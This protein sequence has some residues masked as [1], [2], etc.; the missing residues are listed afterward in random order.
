MFKVGVLMMAAAALTGSVAAQELNWREMAELPRPVAGYMA[1]IVRGKLLIVG[2]SYWENK[3]KHWADLVQAFD[4]GTN[5]WSNLTPLPA[6]R[7]DAASVTIANDLYCFGGGSG[8]EVRADV[9][10]FHNGAW[11]KVAEAD[12]PEPRLYAV[13]ITS[14]GWV[15]VLGGISKAGDYKVMSPAFWRWRPGA[16]KWETLEPLPGP[17]RISHA[18]AELDGAIYVFG[19]ATTGPQ[20]VENLQDAYEYDTRTGK[21]TRLPDLSVANR[22]WWS[23]GVGNRALVL[24]G[25]T[26]DFAKEVY[27]YEPGQGLQPA[28]A[29]PHGLADTKF[30]RIGNVIVGAGGE[31][32]PGI[33]GKWTLA[34]EL[35]RT[36]R[37]KSHSAKESQ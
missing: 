19:G 6:L 26:N 7:S 12:L 31:A 20:D 18:M 9:L 35:P 8:K 23:V 24:A 28:G 1:G 36:P 37:H 29:L 3:Q 11:S 17:G 16:K 33:R 15:Y 27:W 32:G 5:S 10:L 13:A 4:P 34:A 30:F 21:W 25:Y 2:G 22:A 14:G